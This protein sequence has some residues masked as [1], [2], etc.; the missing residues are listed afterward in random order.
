MNIG[1]TNSGILLVLRVLGGHDTPNVTGQQIVAF[2]SSSIDKEGI[3]GGIAIVVYR[4]FVGVLKVFVVIHGSVIDGLLLPNRVLASVLSGI[5]W[6]EFNASSSIEDARLGWIR[7][8]IPSKL[9][10][11]R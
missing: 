9:F 7:K 5:S 3:R 2:S 4:F 10:L 1:R 8:S 6:G 11:T